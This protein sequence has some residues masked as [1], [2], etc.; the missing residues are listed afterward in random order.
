[1]SFG[2]A[3]LEQN[4]SREVPDPE[5][6]SRLPMPSPKL[7]LWLWKITQIIVNRKKMKAKS[8][9]RSASSSSSTRPSHTF[10][11][12]RNYLL[13]DIR[14]NVQPPTYSGGAN[15]RPETV[16][17]FLGTVENLFEGELSDKEKVRAVSFLL[18]E[19]AHL[20]W[21]RVK[22]DREEAIKGPVE[23]WSKFKKLFLEY[24]LPRDHI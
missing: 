22:T 21:T 12:G 4:Q 2:S 17:S 16:L 13:H 11:R 8:P 23:T 7:S 24:F 10:E 15:V 19:R 6:L 5:P 9:S 18:R 14:K 20:W 1:M 3:H